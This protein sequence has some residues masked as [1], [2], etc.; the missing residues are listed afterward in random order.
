MGVQSCRF[1]IAGDWGLTRILYLTAFR[2]LNMV[3]IPPLYVSV[4]ES[5]LIVCCLN[6]PSSTGRF[7]RFLLFVLAPAEEL[8]GVPDFLPQ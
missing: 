1:R 3:C 2:T 7:W 5:K 8:L 6:C 4:R